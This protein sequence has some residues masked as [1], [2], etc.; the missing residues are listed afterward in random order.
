[1]AEFDGVV[2]RSLEETETALSTYARE[3]ERNAALRSARD[4]AA[5]AMRITRARQRAGQI[6][7]LDVLDS[8]RTFADTEA[9]LAASSARIAGA[10]ID[11][12]RSLGGGWDKADLAAAAAK[13][14]A[15]AVA[16]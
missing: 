4:G 10:Q 6:D 11:L 3:I 15:K 14:G 16:S 9:D 2:L 1:M 7:S 12:F 13:S 8:E 5:A